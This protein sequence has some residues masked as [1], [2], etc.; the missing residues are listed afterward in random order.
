[1]VQTQSFPL[2]FTEVDP[3]DAVRLMIFSKLGFRR[4]LL[5]YVPPAL[6]SGQPTVNNFWLMVHQE[7]NVL[8]TR[9]R[10]FLAEYYASLHQ[11]PSP[12]LTMM[13][14]T[15]GDETTQVWTQPLAV[16]QDYTSVSAAACH[17]SPGF[18]QASFAE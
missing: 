7:N 14:A 11:L 10:S 15:L 6:S 3:S 1:M 8:N 2:L 17:P 5:D 13:D 4:V 12:H 18:P 16:D 9:V